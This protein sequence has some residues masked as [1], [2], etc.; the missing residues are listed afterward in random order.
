MSAFDDAG[1]PFVQSILHPTDFSLASQHAFAHALGIALLRKTKLTILE[2]EGGAPSS[3]EWTHHPAV[4]ET[5]VKWG[6]L[7]EGSP[8]SA[9]FNAL[10][11]TV[12]KV[13]V[14]DRS[15]VG[16]TLDYLEYEPADLVVLASAGDD[17]LPQFFRPSVAD[18]LT[19]SA[20]TM[21]LFVPSGG[22]GIIDPDTGTTDLRSILVPVAHDPNPH[23]AVVYAAR[24]AETLPRL[25]VRIG[26]LYVGAGDRPAV[27]LP[28]SDKYSFEWLQE[29]GDVVNTIL[30]TAQKYDAGLIAMATSGRQGIL[31]ALRGSTTEQV[32]KRGPCPLLAVPS[33]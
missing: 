7:Q 30:D 12:K 11:V 16:A 5:L 18:R 23:R 4:R 9:V 25:D 13:R 15:F 27:R 17:G 29:D 33:E 22:R 20:H 31:D 28:E 8:R 1:V 14:R 21:T 6:L 2:V 10:G 19:H 26:L 32:L 3:D 24:A